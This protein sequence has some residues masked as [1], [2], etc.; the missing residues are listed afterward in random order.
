MSDIKISKKAERLARMY[1]PLTPTIGYPDMN[2]A[3]ELA[4]ALLKVCKDRGS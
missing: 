1:A 3:I 4:R 2:A